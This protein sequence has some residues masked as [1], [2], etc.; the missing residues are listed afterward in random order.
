MRGKRTQDVADPRLLVFLCLRKIELEDPCA[1][2]R[3][4]EPI[5]TRIQAGA[6]DDDLRAAR[7]QAFHQHL[8]DVS[9]PDVHAAREYAAAAEA[10]PRAIRVHR[11][12]GENHLRSGL[13]QDRALIRAEQAFGEHVGIANGGIGMLG[14]DGSIR[15][16]FKRS[17][18]RP[19][20]LGRTGSTGEH[21]DRYHR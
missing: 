10:R 15:R 17:S 12:R 9:G 14:T 6:E 16:D 13:L 11:Q 5:G 8:V 3:V 7:L 2:E 21:A 19:A 18:R 4:A 1:A 20:G